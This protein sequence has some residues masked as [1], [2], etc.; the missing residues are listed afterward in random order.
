MATVADL[1]QWKALEAHAHAIKSTHLRQLLSDQERT[2]NMVLESEGFLLDYSRQNGTIETKALLL[3]LARCA[4]DS[5][6]LLLLTCGVQQKIIY[7][8]KTDPVNE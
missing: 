1:P 8:L 4:P 7:K 2:S 6:T 3:D 5:E